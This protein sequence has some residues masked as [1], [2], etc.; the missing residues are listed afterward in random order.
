MKEL[1][2]G[3]SAQLAKALT[4]GQTI[5]VTAPSQEIRNVVVAGLG[6]SGIGANIVHAMVEKEL[7]VPYVISKS[8][9]IP[10]FVN[11]HTL[12]IACSFSGGTEETL[13]ALGKALEKNAKIFCVTSGG[14]M[15]ALAEEKSLDFVQIPNEAPCPRAFLGYS[16]VQLLFALKGY[17]LISDSFVKDLEAGVELLKDQQTTITQQAKELANAIFE[18]QLIVY[19]DTHLLPTIT[20]FQQQINENSKQLCHTNV[21]P[22]MNHNELV[23]WGLAKEVYEKILVVM[24]RTSFD[25]ER[26]SRRMDITKTIIAEK[27]GNV[28]EVMPQ[29]DTFISQNIYLVH[30]FDWA[31]F[32]LSDLNQVDV[33]E[34]KAINHLKSE[35]A[36]F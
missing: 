7:Q 3:F 19:A 25:H 23:G 12:F 33:F 16:F 8:Y 18:K 4:I 17:E 24:V 2:E 27:A 10:N 34:I 35:L 1:I 5:Q 26:V 9:D 30:L 28:L 29:G 11:E 21:L 32:Y 22:E 14:K 31:S 13:T 20:R 36:K 6:G 15:M